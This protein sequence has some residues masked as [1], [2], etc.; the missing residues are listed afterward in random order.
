MWY[1]NNITNFHYSY[2]LYTPLQGFNE[3]GVITKLLV[4]QK[5][6]GPLVDVDTEFSLRVVELKAGV[7]AHAGPKPPPPAAIPM[8]AVSE[9]EDPYAEMEDPA[10]NL[11]W[12][13]EMQVRILEGICNCI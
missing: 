6:P 11:Y 3:I 8:K 7:K 4:L 10:E 12:K 1:Y 5:E 9:E 2:I 13:G